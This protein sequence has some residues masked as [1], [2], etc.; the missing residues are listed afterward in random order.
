MAKKV[1]GQ[2]KIEE[3][4]EGLDEAAE[5]A[6]EAASDE[7][8]ELQARL[9]EAEA[10]VAENLDGWQ[11]A[12][13]EFENYKKRQARNQEQ[14]EA[15]MR[16]RILKRYLEIVDDLER[17]LAEQPADGPGAEWAT[18][19]DLIYRKLLGY[20]AGEGVAQMEI[21]DKTF[22]PNRHEAIVQAESEDHESGEIIEI[23][24]PG[25]MLGERVLRPA[26]V[27]VAK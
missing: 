25:Y 5:E 23:L 7:L 19:V 12:L 14:I 18:G 17:A 21:R 24:Q 13:A 1:N 27:K 22:D 6:V 9:D 2:D 11:R 15:D 3:V 10:K 20:L 8:A 26:Q 16:G 4:E